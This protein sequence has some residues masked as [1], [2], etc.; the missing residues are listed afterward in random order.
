MN[1]TCISQSGMSEYLTPFRHRQVRRGSTVIECVVA[2]SVLI[3][4]M[5]TITTMSFRASRMWIDTGH[6]RIAMN[7]I[8]NQLEQI[9]DAEPEEIDSLVE[10]MAPSSFARESLD[11][12]VI[13]AVRIRDR[14]G[15]RVTVELA[16]RSPHPIAPVE[17]TGW[18]SV[19]S[20]EPSQ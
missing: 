14:S 6:Q 17:L 11:Q 18:I 16:W 3:V 4:A 10:N 12:P 5:G 13:S 2:A 1:L 8:V 20:Q 9:V 7:E 15:D 19:S